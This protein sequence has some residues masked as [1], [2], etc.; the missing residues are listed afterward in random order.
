MAYEQKTMTS[1]RAIIKVGGKAI[2]Y[3]RNMRITETI[4]RGSVK[5]LGR[6]TD[7]EKPALSIQCTWNCDF[8]LIDLTKTGIPGANKRRVNSVEQY[9]DTLV[10]L[11]RPL[12]IYIY[13]KEM[14][15]EQDGVVVST[16]QG[17][18]AILRNVYL[19]SES[20]DVTENQ[21]SSQNQ[22]GEYTEPIIFPIG[23]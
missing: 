14:T 10:L 7:R 20:F 4:Q 9:K 13:K 23:V 22:S 8:Y 11:E 6:L 19:N 17:E 15:S 18:F 2:G 5:G 16:S 3:I 21:V 1:P 12:D